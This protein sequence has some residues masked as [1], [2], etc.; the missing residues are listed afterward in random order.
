LKGLRGEAGID[1]KG[2]VE[3]LERLSF[4]ASALSDIS[5]LDI[6]PVIATSSKCIAVDARILW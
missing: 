5:E 4:L 6:N 2:L 1:W 3:I